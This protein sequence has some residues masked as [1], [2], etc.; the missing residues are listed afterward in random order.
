M[1]SSSKQYI[2]IQKLYREKARQDAQIVHKYANEICS[3]LGLSADFIEEEETLLFCKNAFFLNL[4][5]MKPL[6]A[7]LSALRFNRD[8]FDFSL[9]DEDSDVIWYVMLRAAERF[10]TKC[11]R[12]PISTDVPQLMVCVEELMGE[13][14]LAGKKIKEAYAIEMCRYSG[15]E[16]HTVSAFLGGLA[17]QECIKLI[18]KQYVPI[19]N[20]MVYN[21]I[22]SRTLSFEA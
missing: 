2:D 21:A 12:Y 7:E 17:A 16:I 8:Y 22:Q 15:C 6:E 11:S 10:N 14:G 1:T 19:N 18:T 4:I 3:S 20:T 13:W 9:D 5:R